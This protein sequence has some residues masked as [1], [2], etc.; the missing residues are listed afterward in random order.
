M[1]RDTALETL[2]DNLDMINR[3]GVE[4]I[5]LFGSVARSEHSG[6]SDVDVLVRFKKGEKSFDNYMDLKFFLES[7]FRLDVDLVIEESLKPRLKNA[8][9]MDAVYAS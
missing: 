4:A 1:D 2:K 5:G 9:I 7:V 8:I 6:E 3:F